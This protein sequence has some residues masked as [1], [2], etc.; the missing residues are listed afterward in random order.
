MVNLSRDV[1][2][3]SALKMSKKYV[4]VILFQDRNN[5]LDPPN[6]FHIIY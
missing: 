5:A 2:M 4:H 6:N 3:F 1:P